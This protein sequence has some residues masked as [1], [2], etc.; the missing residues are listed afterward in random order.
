MAA[1]FGL[2]HIL[3]NIL[4]QTSDAADKRHFSSEALLI[5]ASRGYI[6]MA[7]YLVASHADVEYL[8]WMGYAPLH[9]ASRAELP[10]MTKLLLDNN[11]AVDKVRPLIPYKMF[12]LAADEK[13]NYWVFNQSTRNSSSIRLFRQHRRNGYTALKLAVEGQYGA[14]VEILLEAGADINYGTEID[15]SVFTLIRDLG[16]PLHRAVEWG[17]ASMVS[18]LLQKGARVDHGIP[19]PL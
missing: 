15:R 7:R 17:H 11:V 10:A 14:I 1:Y 13:H 8:S 3:K 18:L 2:Q 5:A 16:T 9:Y 6:S 4:D 19:T 12:R